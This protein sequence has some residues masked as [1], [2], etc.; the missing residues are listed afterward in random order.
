MTLQCRAIG[1]TTVRMQRR[2]LG[3]AT[4]PFFATPEIAAL[5]DELWVTTASCHVF[6]WRGHGD[7]RDEPARDCRNKDTRR[8]LAGKLLA[9]VKLVL[10]FT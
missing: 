1:R 10:E 8:H 7:G 4:R 3:E 9:Q 2:S 5:L 6:G